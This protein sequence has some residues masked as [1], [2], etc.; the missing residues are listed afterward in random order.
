MTTWP[1]GDTRPDSPLWVLRAC[2]MPL[3]I[4]TSPW[5]DGWQ[6]PDVVVRTAL[7]LPSNLPAAWALGAAVIAEATHMPVITSARVA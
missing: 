3:V 6:G 5:Y 7:H 1:L 2:T 4:S